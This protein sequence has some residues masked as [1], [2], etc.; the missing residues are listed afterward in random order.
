MKQ[1]FRLTTLEF[2]IYLNQKGRDNF[3]V[4]YG[5]EVKENLTYDHAA[6]ALGAAIMHALSCQGMLDNRKRELKK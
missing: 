5:D 4:V 1:C 2:P 6:N 3:Q